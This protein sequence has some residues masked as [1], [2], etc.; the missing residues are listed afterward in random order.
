MN[1]NI[2]IAKL[3][4]FLA[5]I[6]LFL[7]AGFSI[8]TAQ[9]TA[10]PTRLRQ[11]CLDKYKNDKEYA[12]YY[13]DLYFA[14]LS[15]KT[16]TLYYAD[17]PASLKDI[18]YLIVRIVALFIT[19]VGIITFFFIV[20]HSIMIMTAGPDKE[21]VKK[22]R[23]GL[24]TTITMLGLVFVAYILIVFI[25]VRLGL[26]NSAN[27]SDSFSFIEGGRIIFKFIFVY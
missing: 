22:A 9:S 26:E 27:S 13:Q 8:I 16:N 5:I 12:T 15:D 6:V 2:K 21:K 14:Q 24:T 3:L 4:S 18:Q 23:A 25:A 11:E 19:S 20:K 10:A 17:C 1:F 7:G